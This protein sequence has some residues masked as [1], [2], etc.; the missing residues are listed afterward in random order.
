[1]AFL[2]ATLVATLGS[3]LVASGLWIYPHSLSYFNEAIGGPLNG[4]KHLLGSNVDWGQDLRYVKWWLRGRARQTRPIMIY[5]GSFDP[6][7][8]GINTI[9]FFDSYFGGTRKEELTTSAST[10][11]FDERTKRTVL[12]SAN[13][14]LHAHSKN[15]SNSSQATAYSVLLTELLAR[16]RPLSY[17]MNFCRD[18]RDSR[19][20]D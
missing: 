20:T 12:L 16:S 9:Q 19:N 13:V 6:D 3:W 17:S 15:E 11:E 14:F 2:P 1:M 10:H 8:V 5:K 18:L 4:P 7:S